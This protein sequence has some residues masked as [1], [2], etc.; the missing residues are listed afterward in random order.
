MAEMIE[1]FPTVGSPKKIIFILEKKKEE[2]FVFIIFYII[3]LFIMGKLAK[4]K[5]NK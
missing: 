5:Y 2:S 4:I 1:V 3:P